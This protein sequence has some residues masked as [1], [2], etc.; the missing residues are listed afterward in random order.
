VTGDRI[1]LAEQVALTAADRDGNHWRNGLLVD[2]MKIVIE[3]ALEAEL[4]VHLGHADHAPERAGGN[5]RNGSRRKTVHTAFGGVTIDAPRDRWGTFQPVT[6]GKWQRRVNGIDQ[7]VVPLAAL[8]GDPKEGVALLSR[9]YGPA[10]SLGLTRLI[11]SEIDRRTMP[12]HSRRLDPAHRAILLDRVVIRSRDGRVAATPVQTAVGLRA[13]GGCELL[14]LYAGRDPA[15]RESWDAILADLRRR[16]LS[17]VD[18]VLCDPGADVTGAIADVWPDALVCL[19]GPL[20]GQP[21]GSGPVAGDQLD[22]RGDDI[23][24]SAR[25]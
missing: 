24:L 9:V 23:G 1:G 12:W 8:G 2:L 3:A 22:R 15:S 19:R 13:A 14:T 4:A 5:A 11:V 21:C 6:V 7:L 18:A 16:G 25:A 17:E 20:A 10:A